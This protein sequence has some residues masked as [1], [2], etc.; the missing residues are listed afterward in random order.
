MFK[1]WN[2]KIRNKPK[3]LFSAEK[4]ILQNDTWEM[5]L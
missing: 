2:D 4:D 3:L 5:V 1:F